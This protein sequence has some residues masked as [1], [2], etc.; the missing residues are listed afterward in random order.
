MIPT[1]RNDAREDV[2]RCISCPFDYWIQRCSTVRCTTWNLES[3]PNGSPHDATPE[4]QSQR[5]EAAANVLKKLDPDI[6][7]LQEMRDYDA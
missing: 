2:H 1:T 7:L 5:I 4:K 6:L 3:F